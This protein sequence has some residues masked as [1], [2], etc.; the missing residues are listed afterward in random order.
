MLPDFAEKDLKDS[1]VREIIVAA[2]D[3]ALV[4]QFPPQL[5]FLQI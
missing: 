2:V 4:A 1:E 3:K 5:S